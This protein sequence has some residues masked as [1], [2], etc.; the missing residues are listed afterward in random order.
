M[1][2]DLNSALAAQ[3]TP[4]PSLDGL[5][6]FLE[7]AEE[8]RRQVNGLKSGKLGPDF[9]RS[10]LKKSLPPPKPKEQKPRT[11]EQEAE[12]KQKVQDLIVQRRAR[13]QARTRYQQYLQDHP[14][15]PHDSTDYTKWDLFLPSDDE[16]DALFH[17]QRPELKALQKDAED[18][19]SRKV[20][21]RQVGER[22]RVEGNKLF[23]EWRWAEAYQ[24][25]DRGLS[26][27][28]HNMAL[29]AN[30]ALCS[31]K[32]ACNVQ[33]IEHA[34]KV[35]HIAR[36]LHEQP[37]DPMCLKALLRRASARQA[38]G[39]WKEA[40]RD[41]AEAASLEPTCKEV[42]QQQDALRIAKTEHEQEQVLAAATSAP[43]AP[44]SVHPLVSSEAESAASEMSRDSTQKLVQQ[45]AGAQAPIT[46]IQRVQ[47]MGL[48][49]AED[50][51]P[52]GPW[53]LLAKL[54]QLLQATARLLQDQPACQTQLRQQG[55]LAS[56]ISF[57]GYLHQLQGVQIK[58]GRPA[59]ILQQLQVAAADT[60]SAALTNPSNMTSA[61]KA[62]I[63]DQV[64]SFWT[65]AGQASP[66]GQAGTTPL[67]QQLLPNAL[68][69]AQSS[70]TPATQQAHNG[71]SGRSAFHF[72]ATS[73]ARSI[74]ARSH[75]EQDTIQGPQGAAHTEGGADHRQFGASEPGN[76]SSPRTA[77]AQSQAGDRQPESA[78]W[79]LPVMAVLADDKTGRAKLGRALVGA[80][81]HGYLSGLYAMRSG[82][83]AVKFA[84]LGNLATDKAW[85][86][87]VDADDPC[88]SIL[89]DGMQQALRQEQPILQ[90]KAANLLSNIAAAPHVCQKVA[91]RSDMLGLLLQLVAQR[92]SAACAA[93][94]ALLNLSTN[95]ALA[96]SLI[97]QQHC[98]ERITTGISG[99]DVLTAV[100]CAGLVSRL[101]HQNSMLQS[102]Q[103]SQTLPAMLSLAQRLAKADTCPTATHP[104][105]D[106]TPLANK[107]QAALARTLASCT[108]PS[109]CTFQLQQW[110]LQPDVVGWLLACLD[111]SPAEEE[112]AGNTA[113]CLGNLAAWAPGTPEG[114]QS[115][116][117][118]WQAGAVERLVG[119]M[120]IAGN[121]PARNAAI[122][123]ARLAQDEACKVQLR[124]LDGLRIM[125]QKIKP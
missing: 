118:L 70:A 49:G 46:L 125:Y 109:L 37:K 30:A 6:D 7:Q 91:Q 95:A 21:Q 18:R 25:Y 64:S 45:L 124:E 88:C 32:M 34:D 1:R 117:E 77:S 94:T 103:Q 24:A 13:E 54:P 113:L 111:G 107:A 92:G 110:L 99:D 9:V 116:Q 41:L 72:R 75:A 10:R 14:A 84:I 82:D 39:H 93:A 53:P 58:D 8:V 2:G 20:E 47:A 106:R 33:A 52:T 16:E 42:M 69:T 120:K 50:N 56:L 119:F 73:E 55:G 43:A 11:P 112:A 40:E 114:A 67:Q 23:M 104:G 87:A 108:L 51:G 29:H 5:D 79:I 102:M 36:F 66:H 26:S 122:A 31:L 71:P 121:V 100:H 83:Q 63:A 61:L 86:A 38:L 90:Q 101:C 3:P 19:H 115:L 105:L 62:G 17:S 48:S 85:R 81:L 59:N 15:V 78:A 22:C 76:A 57:H 97:S 35:L 60:L 65:A 68:Q 96:S 80:S 27:D 123:L 28:K 12:L 4:V 98:M 44:P 74:S 89:L